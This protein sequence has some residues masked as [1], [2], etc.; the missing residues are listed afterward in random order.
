MNSRRRPPMNSLPASPTLIWFC[1]VISEC[2]YR[3]DAEFVFEK[4]VLQGRWFVDL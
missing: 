1:I 4:W 2:L 3:D